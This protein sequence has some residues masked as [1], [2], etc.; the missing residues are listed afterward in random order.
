V[1]QKEGGRVKSA[2]EIANLLTV[3][4]NTCGE[5]QAR[6]EEI[7]LL[8]NGET[9]VDLPELG[10]NEKAAVANL[11][12]L[13]ID[14]MAM[15]V[16]SVV[17]AVSF[18]IE[19]PGD[20]ERKRADRKRDIIIHDWWPRSRVLTHIVPRRARWFFAFAKAPV[21]IRPDSDGLPHWY[22]RHPIGTFPAPVTQVGDI[23][24]PDCLFC[25]KQSGKALAM[26]YP[27]QMNRI[28]GGNME[29]L[30]PTY[31]VVEYVDH[32]EITCVV[33][34]DSS[35]DPLARP[36]GSPCEVLHSMPNRAMRPLVVAPGRITLDKPLGQFDGMIGAYQL[37]AR[38]MALYTIGQERAIFPETWIVSQPGQPRAEVL[39]QADPLEG[40]V[41]EIVGGS[42]QTISPQPSPL[43]PQLI[44]RLE[45][46]ERAS[47]AVPAEFS[48]H[49]GSNIRTGRR[50]DAVMSAAVDYRLQ[51]AQVIFESSLEEE[52][53]IAIAVAKAY[54]GNKSFS[55]YVPRKGKVLY[56]PNKDFTDDTHEVR[57]AYAGADAQSLTIAVGQK[58]GLETI[59]R[60]S[61]MELDPLVKDVEVEK[62]RIVGEALERA[63]L[64]SIQ[65]QAA[66]PNGPYQPKDLAR[67][68]RLVKEDRMDLAAAVEK[69]DEEIRQRQA[70]QQAGMLQGP[71]GMPGLAMPGAPGA[72]V[73]AISEVEP[74][75]GRL[76]QLMTQLRRPQMTMPSEGRPLAEPMVA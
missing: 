71:E 6:M 35:Q 20:A 45:Y 48:G 64:S 25:Y 24:P 72:P 17:P 53:R 73:E 42:I 33:I 28:C 37:Q 58:L 11:A 39:V 19:R 2:D 34:G 36:P 49:S 60:E 18:A 62:D 21:M 14:Q 43:A 44:D 65:T 63:F 16:A 7:R 68:V 15:R 3:R 52:N 59:S 50:G 22:D 23:V 74:S 54:A 51:E 67:I 57:Y 12:Q 69:V 30:K 9:D 32:N 66:D 40:T 4:K 26:L 61:A 5:D 47:G 55:M 29:R 27:E 1:D 41:G 76:S 10:K 75:I 8:Y 56:T 38:L 46:A 70:E 13:G 31:D